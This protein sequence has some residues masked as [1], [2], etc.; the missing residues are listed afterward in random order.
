MNRITV[1]ALA[2]CA[3]IVL[4]SSA[5]AGPSEMNV[6]SGI[7]NVNMNKVTDARLEGL[8]EEL[9][10]QPEL[11]QLGTPENGCNTIIGHQGKGGL[12]AG[13]DQDVIILGDVINL[14]Q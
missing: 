11:G 3:L 2:T 7:G 10:S 9:E 1:N 13:V 5:M 14:C 6:R 4:S 12:A 8:L